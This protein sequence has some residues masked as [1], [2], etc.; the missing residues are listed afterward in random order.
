MPLEGP[1]GPDLEEYTE[2]QERGWVSQDQLKFITLEAEKQKAKNV[3]S[4]ITP[5]T[6]LQLV[7][8]IWYLEKVMREV[9]RDIEGDIPQNGKRR[10]KA[11]L[12]GDDALWGMQGGKP[13]REEKDGTT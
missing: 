2:K 12:K 6:V 3:Y 1:W 10:L 8:R 4:W 13:I 9:V 5:G 11:A 7:K